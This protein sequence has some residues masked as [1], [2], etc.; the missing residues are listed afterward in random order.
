MC[1]QADR[2]KILHS[3]IYEKRAIMKIMKMNGG[4]QKRKTRNGHTAVKNIIFSAAAMLA[5]C[6]CF[7]S[8]AWAAEAPVMPVPAGSDTVPFGWLE[9]SGARYYFSPETG[10][11]LTGWQLIDEKQYYFSPETGEMLTG[12]QNI[13]RK[14]AYYFNDAGVLKTS[15]WIRDGKKTYYAGKNGVL[16]SGWE[17]IS[18]SRYYFSPENSRMLTG[19]QKITGLYYYFT[20]SGNQKG[21]LKTNCIAGTKKSGYYYVDKDG[22]RT[23]SAE[24]NAAVQYVRSHTKQGWTAMQKLE[25]CYQALR[26]SYTY[27]HFDGVP[28]GAGLSE[29]ACSLFSDGR[30][31]CYR[32]ASGMACIAT[33]TGYRA[34]VVTGKV[35][36]VYGGWAEHGWAQVLDGGKWKL[37][38]VGMRQFMTDRH[39]VRSYVPA[40]VYRLT[41]E[42]GKAFWKKEA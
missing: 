30:G 19:W 1:R 2:Q 37:C 22:V 3:L 42:N 28:K 21:A 26:D 17:K 12:R 31:N 20:V 33:V 40:A 14:K 13:G 5:I 38:D 36:S 29:C 7:C 10:E 27:R 23:D 25:A 4:N 18:G 41:A 24:M 8:N 34:R 35:T 9:N 32:Y 39:P 15:C 11:M 6:G 16:S